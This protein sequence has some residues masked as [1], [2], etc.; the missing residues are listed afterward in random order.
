MRY[1][2]ARKR[3]LHSTTAIPA[4]KPI[5]TLPV[6]PIQLFSKANFRKYETPIKTAKIPMRFSQ[7]EPMRDSRVEWLSA[8][9]KGLNREEPA[10]GGETGSC[11]RR[12]SV[13][14]GSERG[15]DESSTAGSGRPTGI[16]KDRGAGEIRRNCSK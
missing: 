6:A 3:S 4:I 13:A 7:C 15:C 8:A 10:A 16:G 9:F 1:P 11:A 2:L 14:A 12:E 5:A